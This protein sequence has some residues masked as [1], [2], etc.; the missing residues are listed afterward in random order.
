MLNRR[1]SPIEDADI[2]EYLA[3]RELNLRATL[4]PRDAYAEADYV[5]IATPTDYD[6]HT[7]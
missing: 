6:P 5:V 1:V 2:Q 7:N 3:T 4:D